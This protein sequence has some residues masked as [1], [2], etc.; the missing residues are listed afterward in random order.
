MLAEN[1][2]KRIRS[3]GWS[4]QT[5]SKRTNLHRNVIS[6]II[7]GGITDPRL[8]TLIRLAEGLDMSIDELVGRNS[9]VCK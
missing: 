1:L 8:T 7:H 6:K 4:I 3:L 5:A 2:Q 9:S